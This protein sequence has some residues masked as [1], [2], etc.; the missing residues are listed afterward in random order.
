MSDT[1]MPNVPDERAFAEGSRIRL[2]LLDD[3]ADSAALTEAALR[4]S[5]LDFETCRVWDRQAFVD[6][7]DTFRPDLV[8]S[9]YRLSQIDGLDA[10]ALVRQRS[11]VQP[12]IFVADGLA[13]SVAADALRYGASDY[14]MKDRL[15]R[16]PG[17]VQRALAERQHAETLTLLA[18]RAEILLELP[19]A[20]ERMG[21]VEFMQ[22]GQE[23]AEQITGSRIAFIHF[24]NEDQES[25]ELVTWSRRT[26]ESYCHAAFDKHY[27]VSQAGI[28][29]EALR[30]RRPVV[31]NDY[32]TTPQRRGL[33]EG[34]AELSRLISVPVIESGLVRMM[35]GVGNKLAPYTN[36]DVETVQLI[37]NEIWRI[38]CQRR[39]EAEVA[40]SRRHL[41]EVVA[42]RTRALATANRRLGATQQA[43]D[44]AGI[45]IY[46][47]H[48]DGHFLDAN[49][50][51]C[52]MVGYSREEL[53]GMGVP[54]ID[55]GFPSG[56][57][58][59]FV[60]TASKQGS[61]R[62]ESA[63]RRKD[64][65]MVPVEVTVLF[66]APEADGEMHLIAFVIDITRRKEAE[67]ARELARQEAERL[68]R[69]KGEFLANMSHEIRT[70]L[71]AVIG[72]AQIGQR[73]G[74]G[75]KSREIFGRILDSG[76]LLLGIVND[77]L[78]FSHIEDDSLAVE[79]G[80]MLLGDVI[81]RSAAQVRPRALAK[82]LAF[83][84]E[85]APGLPATCRGDSLRLSQ[86]LGNLLANAVKFTQ[87]GSITLT[88]R[89]DHDQLL[90]RI[91]D[92]GIG[93]SEAELGRLFRPFEQVDGSSTRRFGGTGLG[94]TL[95]KRLVDLMDGTIEVE[96]QPDCGTCFTVRL[97]LVEAAGITSPPTAGGPLHG[98]SV[99][100]AEDNE[101]NRLVLED[102][103][104]DQGC[105][106][107]LVE[108]GRQAVELVRSSGPGAFDL[109]L[110]DI[111]MPEMDGYE[112]TRRIH[113]LVPSLPVVGLTA[114][115]TAEDKARCQAA[116]MAAHVAKPV[117]IHGLISV[118]LE[119]TGRPEVS[120]RMSV[121]EVSPPAH[122]Q[123]L[124][125]D[126]PALQAG[127]RGREASLQRLLELLSRSNAEVPGKLRR[128]ATAGDGG[129]IAFL[130]HR[131]KGT[132]GQLL[133]A[134]LCSRAAMVEAA[135]RESPAQASAAACELADLLQAVL[136]DIAAHLRGGA[137][138][139]NGQAPPFAPSR[140]LELTGRLEAL[141][142]M[143]DT[144][145]NVL[146]GESRAFL[147]Q[148]YGA[149]AQQ[150][151]RQIE[152]FDYEGALA[153]LQQLRAGTPA[154]S[155]QD[156]DQYQ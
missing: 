65:H 72:F 7:L 49:D 18:R 117:E 25:I 105:R 129:S 34:H 26:L 69:V 67:V 42:E 28:W 77:I 138:A 33:P 24:V 100:A 40:E 106:L 47:V 128:A 30:Q 135:T 108:N 85:L 124:A 113:E 153:T 134:A 48:G 78:D 141:A 64:G 95:C 39:A 79:A 84:I 150:L 60:A 86:V 142:A 23:M 91:S 144:A 63:I 62:F 99:L 19:R 41:E 6:A 103:L 136:D 70:P 114:H 54:D 55:P 131:L 81:E 9:G 61:D 98:L 57:F 149:A 148:A 139:G 5:G 38:V 80:K 101:I 96:S 87:Q 156:H 118:I 32:A 50:S 37:S 73:D 44:R 1:T 10:L 35:T 46:W 8:L 94:L 89:C 3:A 126:W 51:A 110:M 20:A 145:A 88:A 21:E 43:M 56:R 16:L 115:A 140:L 29:A 74:D 109:V 83:H 154:A 146:F 36:L 104:V 27:P 76:H 53:L 45:A 152:G 143:N 127:Y 15:G 58:V 102:M 147:E 14:V 92:T 123:A 97:P 31:F 111:Q 130:C 125:I 93:M 13:E 120:R 119:H 11:S 82:G 151:G 107:R 155:G 4:D 90:F 22:F 75:E 66:E 12:F 71:N 59:A 68:A 52:A 132:S 122:P 2:L 116:G 17:A 137:T 133:P 121:P 112:A